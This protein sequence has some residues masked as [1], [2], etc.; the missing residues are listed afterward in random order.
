MPIG[1]TSGCVT[2]RNHGNLEEL[3]MSRL[4]GLV[5]AGG[6]V[7][8][9]A[10]AARA[11][12][13]V[14][15]GNPYRGGGVYVGAPGFSYASPGYGYSSGYSGYAAPGYGYVAPG[16]AY[17]S[18]YSGYVAPGYGYGYPAYGYRAYRP[19][20]RTYRPLGGFGR[21]WRRFDRD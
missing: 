15:I 18:G 4:L 14:S 20:Y 11:Q 2:R 7:L 19:V 6:L 8:G 17:S 5:L 21:G 10:S 9:T 16:Y 1:P 3:T 13:G 12:V